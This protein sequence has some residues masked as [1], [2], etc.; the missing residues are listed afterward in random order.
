MG[1]AL[2]SFIIQAP[3]RAAPNLTDMLTLDSP[4][5]AE[6]DQAYG[7]AEDLPRLL[8]ALTEM[9][10]AEDRA[11]LWF[12]VWRMLATPDA[13][14]TSTYAAVPHLI[15]LAPDL[16]LGERAEALHLASHAECMRQEPSAPRV[17]DDLVAAYAEAVERMPAIVAASVGST[18]DR[19]MAQVFAA[20]LLVGH[21]QPALAARLLDTSPE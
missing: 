1:A 19:E 14:F 12:A 6:L 17:P 21:R 8:A 20:A 13:V 7:S 3:L 4:R 16:P 5:W 11:A 2:T 9:R 18:W 15:A 10:M